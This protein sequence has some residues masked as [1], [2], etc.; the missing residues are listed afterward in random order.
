MKEN[1]HADIDRYAVSL[2][3]IMPIRCRWELDTR[4]GVGVC[5]KGSKEGMGGESIGLTAKCSPWT[6]WQFRT[7]VISGDAGRHRL[8][9][10]TADGNSRD[11]G[12]REVIVL[13]SGIS[14]YSADLWSLYWGK[15]CGNQ[16]ATL[17]NWHLQTKTFTWFVSTFRRRTA[18]KW[19]V[20]YSRAHLSGHA[21]VK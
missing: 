13:V 4:M 2:I 1:I 9:W 15:L 19:Q 17:T 6:H 10:S 8:S 7:A 16:N 3:M 14:G 12:H 21:G 18:S 5:L 11:Y 20:I